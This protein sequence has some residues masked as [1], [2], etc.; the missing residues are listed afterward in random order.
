MVNSLTLLQH[1]EALLQLREYRRLSPLLKQNDSTDNKNGNALTPQNVYSGHGGV[2]SLGKSS[3][4]YG[5][6]PGMILRKVLQDRAHKYCQT[7]SRSHGCYSHFSTLKTRTI[8]A[9]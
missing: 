2:I 7:W 1:G 6:G 8:L 9:G 3:R 4:I 5:D